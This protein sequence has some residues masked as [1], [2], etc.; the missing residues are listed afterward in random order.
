[1]EQLKEAFWSALFNLKKNLIRSLLSV[2]GI[3]IGVAA[4]VALLAFGAGVRKD[5]LEKVNALGTHVYRLSSNYDEK[6]GRVGSL[7][8][9]DVE[10]IQQLRLVESAHP[11]L[12]F[13][14]NIRSRNAL[15]RAGVLGVG[16]AY[17]KAN[18]LHLRE[19]RNFSP[20]EVEARAFLCLINE[21]LSQALFPQSSPL[22]KT[23]FIDQQPWTVVGRY[24]YVPRNIPENQEYRYGEMLVPLPSLLRTAADLKINEILIHIRPDYQGD[25][26]AELLK[27]LERGD[28]NRKGLYRVQSQKQFAQAQL[29]IDRTL[30]FWG[31]LVAFVSLIVGGIG[32]MNV[33]LTT[34]A[35]RTREIGVRRAVGARRKDILFQFL[36]ESCLLSALG[37]LLGLLSG[38]AIAQAIPVL[39]HDSKLVTPEVQ[40]VFLLISVGSGVMLGALFGVYPAVKAS[41]LNP[42]EALRGE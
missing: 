12:Y 11:N 25:A 30:F 6:T 27:A 13:Y 36:M 38:T 39:F 3:I 19:G 4:V 2:L 17:L 15:S 31:T 14:K 26:P 33:M 35:E 40:P 28:P 1:M 18:G 42:A 21:D 7:E 37:G 20:I 24:G 16:S 34:V 9:E 41:H 8:L 22:Q 10:R 23:I 32:M 29:E 5:V